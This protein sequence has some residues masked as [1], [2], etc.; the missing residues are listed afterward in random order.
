MRNFDIFIVL[1]FV[2]VFTSFVDALE[3]EVFGLSSKSVRISTQ[4]INA[5]IDTEDESVGIRIYSK[6]NV[7]GKI[8]I[9]EKSLEN[10]Y[11]KASA[12]K[13]ESEPFFGESVEILLI[14]SESQRIFKVAIE[15]SGLRFQITPMVKL[16]E[17]NYT[18]TKFSYI[19][20]LPQL[21]KAI[22]GLKL[23]QKS[24]KK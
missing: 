20:D 23:S 21:L 18:P 14:E 1:V 22:E 3:I 10:V 13:D 2:L 17:N 24:P 9:D 15:D 7:L 11:I 16:G 5:S 12:D 19:A 8:S 4:S 6:K